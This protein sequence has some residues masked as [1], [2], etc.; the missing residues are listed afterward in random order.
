MFLYKIFRA[1]LTLFLKVAILS[2]STGSIH[3]RK[4]NMRA[5]YAPC[6]GCQC[7]YDL[8]AGQWFSIVWPDVPL[9]GH[10]AMSGGIWLSQL[11]R[12]YCPSVGRG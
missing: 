4:Q 3:E 5:W 2:K 1:H 7:F 6:Y 9:R 8:L 10:T 11:R 12:C